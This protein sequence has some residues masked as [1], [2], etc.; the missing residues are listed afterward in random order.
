MFLHREG[1]PE[2]GEIVFCTVTK[3]QYHAVTVQLDEYDKQGLI[4]ISEV[5]P[6]RIRNIRDFVEE[7]KKVVCK[8]IKVDPDRGQIDVSLRRANESQKRSKADAIK[9]E[10]KAEKILQSL[11][12][13]LKK[14]AEEIYK[15]VAPHVMRHYPWIYLAFDDLIEN[16]KSLEDYGIEKGLAKELEAIVREKIKPKQVQIIEKVTL[17]T[18]NENGL[19]VVKDCFAKAKDVDHD[20]Q[21]AY[22]GGGLYRLLVTEKDFKKAESVIAGIKEAMH[23]EMG[24]KGSVEFARQEA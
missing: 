17:K 1:F 19:Q 16:N 24:K 14:P 4:P 10:Q 6:G 23:K 5:S 7:G 21:I 11:A 20:V 13:K 9:Q 22:M 8:V 2:E 3:I 15:A 12:E 18:F